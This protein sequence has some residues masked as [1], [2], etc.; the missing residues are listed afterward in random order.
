MKTAA[1]SGDGDEFCSRPSCTDNT[2]SAACQLNRLARQRAAEH[3]HDLGPRPTFGEMK[4]VA[5]AAGIDDVLSR[6][7][8]LDSGVVHTIGADVFLPL[9][10]HVVP[11]T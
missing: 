2:R 5:A 1:L 6:F 9:P 4:E 11:S 10:L 3:L 7:S 8:G